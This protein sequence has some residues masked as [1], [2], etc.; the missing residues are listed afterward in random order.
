VL[1]AVVS[2]TV[3]STDAEARHCGRQRNRCCQQTAYQSTGN[4]GCGQR[5]NWGVGCGQVQNSGCQQMSNQGCRQSRCF[6]TATACCNPQSGAYQNGAY[7]SGGYPG[8]PA[9]GTP[10]SNGNPAPPPVEPAVAPA[11]SPGV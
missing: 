5:G 2:F 3:G 10:S 6:T 11:P 1:I 4:F 9:Y 7:Q 8:Q